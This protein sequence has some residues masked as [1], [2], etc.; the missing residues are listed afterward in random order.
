LDE[1]P[2]VLSEIEVEV[3][4]DVLLGTSF[5]A[6]L[7]Y[8]MMLVELAELKIQLQELLDKRFLHRSN[9]L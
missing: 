4:I 1:L 7:P 9:S 5:I 2:R 6:Q 8:R 3:S